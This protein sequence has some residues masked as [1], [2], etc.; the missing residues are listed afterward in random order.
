MLSLI[1][2]TF[3][4]AA[5]VSKALKSFVN[6]TLDRSRVEILIIDNNSTDGTKQAV[7]TAMRSAPC[8]WRYIRE[9]RQGLHY[10]RNRGITEAQGEIVV[11]GDDDIIADPAW[12]SGLFREF[13]THPSTGI[14]GGKIV[15][16]WGRE[17]E[18]W[19]F[20]YGT[21]DLHACF[22]YLNYGEER[23]VMTDGYVFGCNFA[24]RRQLALEVGGS[25]PDTFPA[26]FKH[27]AGTGE[28]GMMDEGRRLGWDAVYLPDAVVYHHIDASRISLAYFVDRYE[29]WAVED[30]YEA[31]RS[32][33]KSDAASHLVLL[34]SERLAYVDTD[35]QGKINPDYY[36]TIRRHWAY[37]VLKQTCRVL[38]EPSL[39]EHITR[40]SYL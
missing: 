35:S 24:I 32:M 10:A 4:R 8:R 37:Q 2:P 7:Q 33:S 15:P 38:A 6:Q 17:P 16:I 20:D 5:Y 3:N 29:R 13:E 1:V 22:A 26:K 28:S 19:V 9:P 25:F 23:L 21:A 27:L 12:L 14:A 18:P 31:F 34:A 30:V 39:Y 11:F 40:K 36:R